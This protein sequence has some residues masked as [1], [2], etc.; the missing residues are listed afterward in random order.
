MAKKKK[1]ATKKKA[2]SKKRTSRR[3]A[4]AP[5]EGAVAAPP[6]EATE[7]EAE[8]APPVEEEPLVI[9]VEFDKSEGNET[10]TVK[11]FCGDDLGKREHRC[12]NL[13][14]P[15]ETHTLAVTY[16][17]YCVYH[18]KFEEGVALIPTKVADHIRANNDYIYFD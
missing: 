18:C 2:A 3:K 15:R 1:A 16:A 4:D 8:E 5:V 9:L 14:R 12:R 10:P 11:R 6:E 13:R 7:P 17:P